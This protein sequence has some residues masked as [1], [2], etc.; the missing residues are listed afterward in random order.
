MRD[1]NSQGLNPLQ[2]GK[3]W[4]FLEQPVVHTVALE[5]LTAGANAD[6]DVSAAIVGII[7]HAAKIIG[8]YFCVNAQST[9]LAAGD[10]STWVITVGG[11]TVFTV[12]RQTVLE[13]DTAVSLGTPADVDADA[14]DVVKLAITNGTNADLNSAICHTALVLADKANYPAP[15]LTVVATDGG[16]VTIADGVKGI[17]A[18]SPGASDNDEIY[19]AAEMENVKFLVGK[20]F[21]FESF[22]QFTEQNTD[23]AN[24]MGLCVMNAVA[25]EALVDDG[26]GPK[27][28]GDYVGIWK[29]DGG[30]KWYAGAQSNGTA[31]PATDTVS[32]VTAGGSSYQRLRIK[33]S[34]ETSTRAIAEFMVDGQNIG[35]IHFAY[36]SAT[37]MQLMVGVKNGGGNA[38]TL[39]VDDFGYDVLR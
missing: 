19:M 34:C 4:D 14:G 10:L 1:I 37:E 3:S 35:T 18:L 5:P 23:D 8:G 12:A 6:D 13:A 17:C 28:T 26:L 39:N 25:A 21:V 33:V 2:Y 9:G 11:T 31:I 32:D 16:T 24:V 7:P 22:I 20:V 36:A 38:E 29:I 27:A 30:T 15:G